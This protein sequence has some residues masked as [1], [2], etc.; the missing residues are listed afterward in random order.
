MPVIVHRVLGGVFDACL[1]HHIDVFKLIG[2]TI[3]FDLFAASV[4]ALSGTIM[5]Q[6]YET[7]SKH[8]PYDW[9]KKPGVRSG[10][11]G[12]YFRMPALDMFMKITSISPCFLDLV[13]I[14]NVC[15]KWNS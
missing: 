15:D 12:C 1:L 11:L 3:L 14:E 4:S 6:R 7:T 10:T 5:E 9:Q 8:D 2:R 13:V